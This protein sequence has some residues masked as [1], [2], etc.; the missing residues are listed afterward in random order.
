MRIKSHLTIYQILDKSGATLNY[1]QRLLT[2]DGKQPLPALFA[3]DDGFSTMPTGHPINFH[4]FRFHLSDDWHLITVVFS[5]SK[6]NAQQ[7]VEST[8]KMDINFAAF[9]PGK[10]HTRKI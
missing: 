5:A 10:K 7:T 3:T 8:H 4:M 1:F 9:A 6:P 2:A